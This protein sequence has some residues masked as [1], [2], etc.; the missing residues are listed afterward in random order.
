[1][2]QLSFFD[3][4]LMTWAN[5]LHSQSPLFSVKADQAQG[6]GKSS[7]WKGIIRRAWL[8]QHNSSVASLK[9][10]LSSPDMCL[11]KAAS[12]IVRQEA[13]M[14]NITSSQ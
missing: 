3:L 13:E 6:A 10:R 11:W 2:G 4:S 14:H 1:L 8:S 12:K 5:K 7:S 9:G